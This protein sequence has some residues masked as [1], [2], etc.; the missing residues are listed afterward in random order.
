MSGVVLYGGLAR[1]R[2]RTGRSDVNVVVL[3]QR[4]DAE[5]L[6]AIGPALQAARR[7][8]AIDAMLMTPPEVP[9]AALDFPTKFLDIQRH[10][11]LLAGDDP[12]T[13][14]QIPAAHVRRRVAQSLRNML[15][16]LRHRYVVQYDDV[17]GLK[18]ALADLARPLAIELSA[19]LTVGG[20]AGA[21]EDR[22]AG[23]YAAAA[24]AFGLDAAALT[25]L[26]ALREGVEPASVPALA[27][28]LLALLSDV[29]TQ[30]DRL[31]MGA[32]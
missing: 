14:L 26:A 20:H 5:V 24:A 21:Q 7:S 22:T 2:F 13:S 15:L 29:A 28:G 17:L 12:F 8:A 31:A 1:G 23:I 27:G 6:T 11:L 9:L 19:L 10:H 4:I 18:A 3:L 25:Q 30:A 32:A 16:R